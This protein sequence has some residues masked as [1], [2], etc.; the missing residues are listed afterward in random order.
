MIM[1]KA[2]ANKMA[3]IVCPCENMLIK[4]LTNL[5]ITIFKI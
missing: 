5:R 1:I 2:I 3:K 4:F